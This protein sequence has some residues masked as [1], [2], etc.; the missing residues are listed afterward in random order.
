[1]RLNFVYTILLFLL[2]LNCN[3]NNPKTQELEKQYFSDIDDNYIYER[4]DSL[5][6]NKAIKIN[7]KGATT[8]NGRYYIDSIYAKLK[9][10][11]GAL[12]SVLDPVKTRTVQ[13]AEIAMD[14][15]EFYYK[16]NA[17]IA[18]DFLVPE[19]YIVDENNHGRE[20]M[21]FQIH[22][23]PNED[24]TWEYYRNNMP[25]NR[26][27]IAIYLGKN[28]SDYYLTIRYGLN[29][30]E[31]KIYKDYKWFL[32]GYKN[33][34]TD[35][36]YTIKLNYKLSETNTGFIRSWVN[37]ESFTPFNGKHNMVYGTNMH[38]KAIPYLKLGLY[39]PWPDSH[40]HTVIYDNLVFT[41]KIENLLNK[42]ELDTYININKKDLKVPF[43]L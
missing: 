22:S 39:R 21:I 43:H 34:E 24:E 29:G 26:P 9:N 41:N 8:K 11:K 10:S 14:I 7:K 40:T 28:E 12:A 17:Y 31:D 30:D 3:Q 35:K 33:I 32:A 15:D 23:K 25:F 42:E 18:F 13:R 20:T 2:L 19:T 36:W 5:P 16:D 38:N 27:S 4:F 37:G 1:M 6:L